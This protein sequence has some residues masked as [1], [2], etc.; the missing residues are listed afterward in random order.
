MLSTRWDHSRRPCPPPWCPLH[1]APCW[2]SREPPGR[3][4]SRTTWPF[5]SHCTDPSRTA[6]GDISICDYLYRTTSDRCE[7]SKLTYPW[8][9]LFFVNP[10]GRCWHL[11][12]S[13][14][15]SLRFCYCTNYNKIPP[16]S[17]HI[18]KNH[19]LVGSIFSTHSESWESQVM[20]TIQSQLSSSV[21][22]RVAVTTSYISGEAMS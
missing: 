7:S 4:D 13:Q 10:R 18:F 11:F 17:V 12:V 8:M 5:T 16:C 14:M 19:L 15:I 9:Y 21:N 6:G 20:Q 3:R 2:S 22:V 1:S